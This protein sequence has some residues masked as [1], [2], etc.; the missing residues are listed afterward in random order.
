MMRIIAIRVR[1]VCIAFSCIYALVGLGAFVQY[2]FIEE[3]QQFTFPIGIIM[4]FV[5]FS[6]NLKIDRPMMAS[7]PFVFGI[8]AVLAY[9]ASGCITGFIGTS[10]FNFIVGKMGGI[11]TWF[12]KMV[13]DQQTDQPIRDLIG[14]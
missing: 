3:M 10:L 13:D 5:Y 9:A 11:D 12:V 7:G 14:R 1:P 8:A 2:C 6:F 4:P